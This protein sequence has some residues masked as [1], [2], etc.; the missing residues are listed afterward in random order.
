MLTRP[1]K[2]TVMNRIGIFAP[3]SL[4]GYVRRINGDI[5]WI[6]HYLKGRDYGFEKFKAALG[7]VVINRVYYTMHHSYDLRWPFGDLPCY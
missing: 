1:R 4:D 7:G 5:D 2:L 6:M 3:I